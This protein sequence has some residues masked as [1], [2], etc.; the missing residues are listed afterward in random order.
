MWVCCVS[1]MP[2]VGLWVCRSSRRRQVWFRNMHRNQRH[3]GR[4]LSQARHAA[5]ARIS[6]ATN[7]PRLSDAA[8]ARHP[9]A[10]H[11]CALLMKPDRWLNASLRIQSAYELYHISIGCGTFGRS[12]CTTQSGQVHR[13]RPTGP[14]P[15]WIV[16]Y[17]LRTWLVLH[18][19]S[20]CQ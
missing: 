7:E 4:Q 10:G 19:S 15:V 6:R 17:R 11:S 5:A 16:R 8:G 12:F 9:P 14:V 13:I 18:N 2:A 1:E 20:C 3:G